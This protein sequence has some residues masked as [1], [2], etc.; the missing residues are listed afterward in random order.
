MA[1]CEIV[2]VTWPRS[3]PSVRGG[4]VTYYSPIND[5]GFTISL[6]AGEH[7]CTLV[8]EGSERTV[9]LGFCQVRMTGATLMPETSPYG[10]YLD[11]VLTDT[12]LRPA[13]LV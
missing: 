7:S 8:S 11:A 10:R 5:G 2:V 6:P 13:P 9:P 3:E 12:S 4:A 1:E